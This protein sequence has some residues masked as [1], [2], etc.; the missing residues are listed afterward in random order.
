MASIKLDRIDRKII[1]ELQ[2]D[3]RS[4]N[5]ELASRVHLLPSQCHEFPDG[6]GGR[7]FH[8]WCGGQCRHD[9]QIASQGYGA[10]HRTGHW[11]DLRP[12][13]CGELHFLY[14]SG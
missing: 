7:I 10:L 1:R 9:Y 2:L 3:G 14:F 8:S 4:T 11:R 6:Q 12:Q 5:V 13:I